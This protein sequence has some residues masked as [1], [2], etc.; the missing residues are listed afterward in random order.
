MY[1]E[2][3][4][5]IKRN[6]ANNTIV[7]DGVVGVGKTT[8]MD[9]LSEELGYDKFLEPVVDNPILDK[10][11]H[12]RKRYAFTLQIFFLN[13]RFKMLKEA[14]QIKQQ[15][16]MDRSIYGDVIF[17]KLLNYNQEMDDPEFDIYMELLANMLDHIEP[18]KLMIYLKI[19]TDRAIERIKARGRDFEQVVEREYWQNLNKEYNE[20]FSEY[21]LSPLLVIDAAKYDLVSNE[22][23]KKAVVEL[24]KAELNKINQSKK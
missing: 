5:M 6:K 1:K 13:R 20:Y 17:A 19:D 18:P 21:N 2:F 11:Y 23:D 14:A 9:L 7:I 3:F 16:L 10:F 12:D 24:I 22:S 4:K 15:T 8:L